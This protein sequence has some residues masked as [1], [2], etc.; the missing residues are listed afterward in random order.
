MNA[1]GVSSKDSW[2][3]RY[4][5]SELFDDV[6]IALGVNQNKF[7]FTRN[8]KLSNI[9][10]LYASI[11][12]LGFKWKKPIERVLNYDQFAYF[13]DYVKLGSF[14]Q[15][16]YF[17]YGVIF[18]LA[19]SPNRIESEVQAKSKKK[20]EALEQELVGSY[21]YKNRAFLT[22]V[23]TLPT[24]VFW[25]MFRKKKQRTQIQNVMVMEFLRNWEKNK[26]SV[27]KE[28]QEFFEEFVSLYEKSDEEEF[29][30]EIDSKLKDLKKKLKQKRIVR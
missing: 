11:V 26:D 16:V 12:A 4:V 29:K 1:H 23:I 10:A 14:V 30:K 17:S 21:L 28:L 8:A 5:K 15:L 9:A 22:K 24:N 13:T 25:H 6:N 27:P 19:L 3:W 18:F 20:L 2:R 7:N